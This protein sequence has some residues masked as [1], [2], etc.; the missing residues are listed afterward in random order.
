MNKYIIIKVK[1]NI[2]R[3]IEKCS[4]YNISLYDINYINNNE[5]LVKIN[6]ENYKNIKRYNYYSDIEIY[7]KLGIDSIKENIYK[8][9]YFILIFIILL[10]LMYLISNIILKINVI[11]SNKN[12]RELVINELE[13][14]GIKKYSYKKKF[15][16]LEKIKNKILDN[17]KDKLEWISITN[18]G[19]TYIVRIEERIIDK[20]EIEK[21][22]CNIIASKDALITNIY[23]TNGEII[24]NVN[25][26][27]K[28]G[29]ILVSGDILL[30]DIKKG[31][32][33]ANGT[34]IGKVWYNTNVT[35][36]RN[37]EKK[38]YT[39]NSRYNIKIN[40]KIL[41]TNKYIKYDK[42]Y[43]INNKYISIYKELEY[44]NKVYKYNELDSIKKS[45]LE[46]D[47]KFKN[48][49]G[50]NGKIIDKKILNK[51]ITNN[52][53]DLNVFVVTLENIGE[54]IEINEE[55]ILEN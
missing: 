33:C 32:T 38:E 34:I 36:D 52:K 42:K 8:L 25:D 2:K 45:L 26:I 37:Y 35:L 16:E 44:Y 15:N 30:N 51:T 39:G 4:K 48:K 41:K 12:V 24:V 50:N 29:D 7:S 47:N 6:K 5:I 40:N 31:T 19:M 46:I 13:N 22:Y 17:N 49:L 9:K 10:S 23:A 27:V 1:N 21:E 54:S 11:H 53:V 43:I 55:N 18:I 14:Y 20:K 3:F 28:K